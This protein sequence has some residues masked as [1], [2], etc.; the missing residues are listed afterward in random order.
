L[1]PLAAQRAACLYA[2]AKQSRKRVLANPLITGIRKGGRKIGIPMRRPHG[3]AG[4]LGTRDALETPFSIDSYAAES[5]QNQQAR[6]VGDVL[7]NDAS[8]HV[9]RGFGN[10][11]ESHFVR[12]FYLG[13]DDI[14]YDGLC[15]LLPRQDRPGLDR[16]KCRYFH[17][18]PSMK[19]PFFSPCN[20]TSGKDKPFLAISSE[21]VWYLLK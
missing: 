21:P 8:V 13:S 11:Q 19:K 14:A 16:R 6:G 1:Y 15:V 3:S 5:I 20:D 12:S 18:S 9:A 7:Q 4:I 17:E 2:G 10:F